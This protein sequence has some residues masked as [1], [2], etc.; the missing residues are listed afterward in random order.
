MHQWITG[1]SNR[2]SPSKKPASA[3]AEK[4]SVTWLAYGSS[5]THSHHGEYPYHAAR[6]L[7]WNVADIV[8][9]ALGVNTRGGPCCSRA[10]APDH[11]PDGQLPVSS[12][13]WIARG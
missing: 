12:S 7:R 13:A 1:N 4:P 9:A 2:P 10:L 5:I 11:F 3:A 8:T 6:L